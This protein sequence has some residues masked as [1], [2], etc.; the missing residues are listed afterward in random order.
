MQ[1]KKVSCPELFVFLSKIYRPTLT[2][3]RRHIQFFS[4]LFPFQTFTCLKCFANRMVYVQGIIPGMA[5]YIMYSFSATPKKNIHHHHSVL[6]LL[7]SGFITI[8]FLLLRFHF[9]SCY[10][11]YFGFCSFFLL[12][13]V[14]HFYRFYFIIC[15]GF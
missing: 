6:C 5:S 8:T 11:V 9:I 13:F 12:L 15:V 7:L 4:V 1:F 3:H 14:Y 2:Q 10:H